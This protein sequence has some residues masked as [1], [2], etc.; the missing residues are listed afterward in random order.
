MAEDDGWRQLGL[1]GR[2]RPV[3]GDEDKENS[4]RQRVDN[5]L[6]APP[7]VHVSIPG[8]GLQRLCAH[9]LADTVV[10]DVQRQWRDSTGLAAHPD[11]E[12]GSPVGHLVFI[13][14]CMDQV[15]QNLETKVHPDNVS[16]VIHALEYERMDAEH[17][18]DPLGLGYPY[19]GGD[20]RLCNWVYNNDKGEFELQSNARSACH[21]QILCTA[22]WQ[23]NERADTEVFA[24]H[25]ADNCWRAEG[26]I[27]PLRQDWTWWLRAEARM[28]E[29]EKSAQNLKLLCLGLTQVVRQDGRVIFSGDS[30]F[31]SKYCLIGRVS[32]DV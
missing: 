4:K 17:K 9:K 10:D 1:W 15:R 8:R 18:V 14:R 29:Q 19:G 22:S 6:D 28:Q 11:F 5:W 21:D 30:I 20:E 26:K 25:V 13:D 23:H 31:D 12:S 7:R 16:D 32:T 3:S 27:L 2:A 24:L